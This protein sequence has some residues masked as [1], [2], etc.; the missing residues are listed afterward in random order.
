[1][2]NNYIH[3]ESYL[4]GKRTSAT[5]GLGYTGRF[6]D[7]H[8]HNEVS[9]DAKFDP[10]SEKLVS[11][12]G[13]LLDKNLNVKKYFTAQFDAEGSLAHYRMAPSTSFNMTSR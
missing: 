11:E 5:F 6:A 10:H 3:N 13:W 7:R 1:L 12:H 9:I 2:G 4:D 8:T